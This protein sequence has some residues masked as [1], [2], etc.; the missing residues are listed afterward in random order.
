MKKYL[1]FYVL[2]CFSTFNIFAQGDSSGIKNQLSGGEKLYLHTDKTTYFAGEKIWFRGYLLNTSVN[3]QEQL[4][5]YIYVELLGDS[6]YARVKIR[7]SEEG[8]AGYLNLKDDMK[9]GRY[10]LRGYTKWM[11]NSPNEYMFSKEITIVTPASLR[12]ENLGIAPGGSLL[13]N[14][15][16][17]P[18]VMPLDLQFFP[19]SGRYFTGE[20]A[21][22]A[23][24][25]VGSDGLS[26]EVEGSLFKSDGSFI[27]EIKSRHKG[28]GIINLIETEKGGYYVVVNDKSGNQSRFDLPFPENEGAS[29]S[30]VRT[31]DK[32]S[33]MPKIF[34][35]YEG[36]YF[37]RLSDGEYE[38]FSIQVN[39]NSSPLFFDIS[40]LPSGVNSAKITSSTG[41]VLAERLFYIHKKF[42]PE[43]LIQSNKQF[44]SVR[45][46]VGVNINIAQTG[47]FPLLGNFSISVTDSTLVKENSYRENIISYMS[48]S[49][50]LKG[51][52]EEAGYY[53]KNISPESERYLDLLMQTQ[54]WRYYY[55]ES[56]IFE[57]EYTQSIS[58]SVSGLFR[59]EAKNTILM[60][61]AP[62]IKFQQA[63]LLNNQSSFKVE[64][65]DFPDSTS[66]LF[67][68]SGRSGGQLYGLTIRD[69]I[70]PSFLKQIKN[71]IS[72][73]QLSKI[74]KSDIS[75]NKIIPSKE[76]DENI[77]KR[78]LKEIYVKGESKDRYTPKYNPSPFMQRFS[79]F[80]LK[81]RA[82]LEQ[83]DQMSI[84]DFLAYNYPGLTISTDSNGNRILLSTRTTSM[85]GPSQ[86]LVY[87][88]HMRWESTA[89]LDMYGYT[90]MDVENIAFLRGNEGAIYQSLNGVILITTRR[91][92]E[93]QSQQRTNV[94]KIYPTGYQ[95]K[96][97]F[98]SPK[99][100]TYMEKMAPQKD[101]R[102]TLYWNPCV[103]TD[104][105]GN[106]NFSFYTDDKINTLNVRIEGLLLDGTPIVKDF[107]LK[108]S[109]EN[110]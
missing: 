101:Y 77:Q 67:G 66:F 17:K 76:P 32:V 5:G 14:T 79:K 27:T 52:V 11:Q 6:L 87:V 73:K 39:Y 85:S 103:K 93:I 15:Y 8:F 12:K 29:V 68:I 71:P 94:Q 84:I 42:T 37:L 51:Y 105:S 89:Q 80:Q 59:K 18:K 4:S 2:L 91:G 48:L 56:P 81:E 3:D 41:N 63:Y 70:L 45:D 99:Y 106:G 90:V 53:F 23:F 55:R 86:P 1:L 95:T 44:Y 40:T 35:L 28:M 65:L 50:E 16:E 96:V 88:D 13:T 72:I 98:Y 21:K 7:D 49:A 19:E 54:G 64:G 92:R 38:Y 83:Y 78:N 30:V 24:K 109:T 9:A 97:K 75:E 33:I 47:N 22:I 61:F 104:S 102:N 46:S 36:P 34:K 60:I 10:I 69:E 110:P 25:A 43:I 107:N 82:D 31:T 20:P 100:S 26:A 74:G 62:S 58:G 57:K 108:I